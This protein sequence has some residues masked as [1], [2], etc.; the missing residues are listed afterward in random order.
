MGFIEER[1]NVMVTLRFAWQGLLKRIGSFLVGTS[2]EFDMALYT[3]CFLS[4]RG[5]QCP[6]SN[7]KQTCLT[8]L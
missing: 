4:R 3:L 8:Q 6:V 2:P 7:N 1:G 5:T